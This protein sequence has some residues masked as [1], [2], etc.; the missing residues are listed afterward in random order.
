MFIMKFAADPAAAFSANALAGGDTCARAML[1]GL[2]LGAAHGYRAVPETLWESLAAR[3]EIEALLT[4]LDPSGG[5]TASRKITF[6]SHD[7]QSLDARLE[8][9]PGPLRGTALFAHCFTC[10][11]DSRAAVSISRR[12][13]AEGIA[14]LRFDFTGLG[15]SEGDFANSSFRTNV[16]DLLAA[17]DHLRD[18]GQPPVLLIGHSLGGAAVLAAA[19]RIPECRG[20]ATIG[21]P[22]DPEHVTALFSENLA[23]IEQHGEAEITLAGRSF[24]IGKRFLDDLAEHCQP[25]EIAKL[26]RDLLI[27]HAPQDAVVGIDNARRIYEAARHPK[28]FLSLDRAD[29]LLTTPGAGDY[30]ARIMAAWG[31]R[32]L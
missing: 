21:A 20:V 27:L 30:A 6:R 17:S 19:G 8:V 23:E 14:T 15:S 18:V 22:A 10:G 16:D 32:L 28:S 25:C 5:Q 11:K 12:L 9:P 24:R 31:S 29:H 2:V 13:A 4:L 7:G 1:I 3:R 26:G